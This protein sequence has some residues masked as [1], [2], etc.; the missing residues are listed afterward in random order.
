[1]TNLMKTAF[2]S[3]ALAAMM[4]PAVA[5]TSPAPEP[6]QQNST[7]NSRKENQQDRIGQGIQNGSLTPGE[8]ANLEHKESQINKEEHNMRAQDGGKLTAAD[9]ATID[10]Q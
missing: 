3:T 8:A 6:P 1:M 10:K 5:Q 7:I 9:R 4:L 2:L